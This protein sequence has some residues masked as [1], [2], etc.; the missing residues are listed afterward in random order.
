MNS[1]ETPPL[2]WC[3]VVLE[4]QTVSR[5]HGG[6]SIVLKYSNSNSIV[7]ENKLQ[8]Y[9]VVQNFGDNRVKPNK[10]CEAVWEKRRF[11]TN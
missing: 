9:R 6:F 4:Y 7:I 8:F 10:I 2:L 5:I 3:I 11:D 1:S